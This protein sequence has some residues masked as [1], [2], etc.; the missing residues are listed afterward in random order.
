MRALWRGMTTPGVRW[1]GARPID[2]R[3]FLSVFANTMVDSARAERGLG[4]N[5]YA[6][7]GANFVNFGSRLGYHFTTLES[8]CADGVHEN[9]LIFRFKGGAADIQRRERRVRFI[10]EVLARHDFEVDRRQDLLN[11]W[12]KKLPRE[13]IEA[14]LEMLGR[15]MGC[16]RQLD[17]IM[18]AETSVQQCI[19]AFMRGDYAFFDFEDATPEI[20]IT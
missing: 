2:M 9:Y 8:V 16:A 5:S 17:V 19:D 10:Q 12:V 15:L 1:S 20:G 13:D 18:H 4:D 14:K 7:V 11:A 3:G 6:M